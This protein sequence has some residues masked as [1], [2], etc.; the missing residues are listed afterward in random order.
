MRKNE[1]KWIESRKRWQINV[2][3]EGQRRTFTDPT[4]GRKGKIAAEQKADKWLEEK[5]TSENTRTDAMLDRYEEQVQKSTSKAHY[6]QYKSHI[7][8]WIKPQIGYKKIGKVTIA[9]LQGVINHAFDKGNLSEKSLK[10]IRACLMSFMNFCL[11]SNA[12]NIRL[13]TLKIPSSARRSCKKILAPGD[14]DKLFSSTMTTWRNKPCEDFYINAYRFLAITGL[15][16]GELIGLTRDNIKGNTVNVKRSINDLNE[17]TQ[18][19]N[20]NAIR[21]FK[22]GP[23][24]Q[25]ILKDQAAMLS[26]FGGISKFV[27]PNKLMEHIDQEDFRRCWKRYCIANQFE[28]VIAPYELRHTF[29][30]VTDEMPESLKKPYVGHG[31][32][33][34]TEGIYGHLK[35]GDMER[36]AGYVESAFRAHIGTHKSTQKE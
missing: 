7:K 14:L 35:Q 18:G 16:P 3:N 23:L 9:D 28:N 31:K 1:A 8:I 29:V 12:T 33:M 24:A 21:S 15:R 32:N 13:K 17:V 5:L 19:K 11:D 25:Q 10:N 30:S 6:N 36:A 20:R 34:D 27:F 26:K 22:I 2:Q 4:P